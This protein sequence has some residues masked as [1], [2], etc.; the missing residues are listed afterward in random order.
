MSGC[1]ISAVTTRLGNE[2]VSDFGEEASEDLA[3]LFPDLKW[4]WAAHQ[5]S[6][7]AKHIAYETYVY[8]RYIPP[9]PVD[10]GRLYGW[11]AE[12]RWSC[13]RREQLAVRAAPFSYRMM[14]ES[15]LTCGYMGI[16]RLGADFWPVMGRIGPLGA[17]TLGRRYP[18]VDWHQLN[19]G[20]AAGSVV[21]AGK[22]GPLG[23]MR[24]EALRAATQESEGRIFIEQ[25]LLDPEKRAKL[26]DDLARQCQ[27]EL[28]NRQRQMILFLS[29]GHY[30]TGMGWEAKSGQLYRLAGEVARALGK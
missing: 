28:D 5:H 2:W 14:P 10:G 6:F 23:T 3:A 25:A 9:E 21:A 4:A 12:R 8:H 29:S 17:G 11:Q 26:G 27:H 16:S 30:F 15:R 18:D 1:L 22:D 24:F 20:V 7:N 19:F 13:N